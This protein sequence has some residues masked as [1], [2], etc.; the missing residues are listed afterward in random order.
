M[1][2]TRVLV[3]ASLA[4]LFGAGCWSSPPDYV[5]AP[6]STPVVV[7]PNKEGAKASTGGAEATIT[8]PLSTDLLVSALP[9]PP[10]GWTVTEP[11]ESKLPLPLPD[12]TRAEATKLDREYRKGG[13]A[14]KNVRIS[15]TDTRGIPALLQFM[16]SFEA[17]ETDAGYRRSVTLKD[18]VAW[19]SYTYGP[20]REE[21][22]TGSMTIVNRERFLI[23]IDGGTGVSAAELTALATSFTYD[24]LK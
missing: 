18:S 21:D 24:A 16:Q 22:G 20:K 19:I 5:Q 15:I 10:E 1:V 17:S 8:P 13:D 11:V 23:Q 3:I 12:G 7:Q 6:T 4:T 14:V 9:K 2:F